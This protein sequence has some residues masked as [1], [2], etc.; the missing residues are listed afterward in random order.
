MKQYDLWDQTFQNNGTMG[1]S[2]DETGLAI[3]DYR[4]WRWVYGSTLNSSL[5]WYRFDIV[6]SRVF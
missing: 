6:H 2:E 3:V 1:R 5:L 4:S